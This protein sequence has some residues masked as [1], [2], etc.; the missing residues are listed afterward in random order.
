MYYIYIFTHLFALYIIDMYLYQYK[1][2]IY[3][4]VYVI[5][6]TCIDC[7]ISPLPLE[8][9][10]HENKDFVFMLCFSIYTSPGLPLTEHLWKEEMKEEILI[11][12]VLGYTG[13]IKSQQSHS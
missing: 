11:Q 9:N 7:L 12:L 2:Y 3:I 8:Y 4:I 1:L 10:L 5:C 6:Y 13:I